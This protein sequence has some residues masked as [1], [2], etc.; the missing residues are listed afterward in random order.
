MLGFSVYLG[1]PFNS[2]YIQNMLNLGF[3]TVFTSIQIPEE[4]NHH[5]RLFELQTYLSAFDTALIID[6][7]E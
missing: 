2:D 5:S 3:R 7:N 4:Q 1:K 6:V